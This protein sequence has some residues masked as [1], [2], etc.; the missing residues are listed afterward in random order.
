MATV[1]RLERMWNDLSM[2]LMSPYLWT[3]RRPIGGRLEDGTFETENAG[4]QRYAI[5]LPESYDTSTQRLPVVYHLHGARVSRRGL[6]LD[7]NRLGARLERAVTEGS[8]APALIVAPGNPRMD[9]WADSHDGKTLSATAVLDELIPQIEQSF[10]ASREPA[11][12]FLSGFSMG[13]FGAAHL[14]GRAPER[15][16]AVV[17]WDAAIHTWKTMVATRQVIAEQI[18]GSEEHFDRFSPDLLAKAG[19]AAP[20]VMMVV[21][22]LTGFGRRFRSRLET[23]GVAISYTE[24]G[25][26]HNL[27]CMLEAAGGEVMAF[28]TGPQADRP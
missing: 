12:R 5:Y 4:T 9:M 28:L 13:G 15:F 11:Q 16:A 24:T 14:A 8:A 26:S 1:A 10:R 20:R 6:A 7:V 19:G 27:F 25:C 3:R 17:L 22:K 2:R 21:G 23:A 18:F